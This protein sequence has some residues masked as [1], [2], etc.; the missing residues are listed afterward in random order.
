[1]REGPFPHR[2]WKLTDLQE[3]KQRV[4]DGGTLV[5]EARRMQVPEATLR[6]AMARLVGKPQRDRRAFSR[7]ALLLR[8]I[9]LR[10]EQHLSWPAITTRVGYPHKPDTLGR[11]CMR[12]ARAHDHFL[13]SNFKGPRKKDPSCDET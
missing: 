9:A 12:Y 7:E 4:L 11:E 8:A 3:V 2:K 6:D 5:A 10:N 1:M 13:F